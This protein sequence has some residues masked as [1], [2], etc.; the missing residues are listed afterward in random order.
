MVT[1]ALDINTDPGCSRAMD[2]DMALSRS[3]GPHVTMALGSS[4]G[5][6]D[7]HGPV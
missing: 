3:S 7:L 4:E 2:S 1:G 5:H 6:S